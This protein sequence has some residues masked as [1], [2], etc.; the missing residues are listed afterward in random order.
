MTRIKTLKSKILKWGNQTSN[1]LVG[2]IIQILP[3]CNSS[4]LWA[5]SIHFPLLQD[6][7]FIL[8]D[9]FHHTQTL[10]VG[11]CRQLNHFWFFDTSCLFSS[12]MSLN[13]SFWLCLKSSGVALLDLSTFGA[14]ICPLGV[15]GLAC[16]PL[17]GKEDKHG[18]RFISS[19]SG[20]KEKPQGLA[21][22]WGSSQPTCIS[23]SP[24]SS[25]PGMP[26]T[27]EAG[28]SQTSQ[29]SSSTFPLTSKLRIFTRL[30][31]KS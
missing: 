29:C 25:T 13:F 28:D 10:N 18:N 3:Y 1:I 21:V 22:A 30:M 27:Q 6:L 2:K 19:C 23:S 26:H 24:T 20:K 7:S 14:S 16:R 17:T 31:L 12:T 8:F 5:S 9:G 15:L 11:G 4:Y